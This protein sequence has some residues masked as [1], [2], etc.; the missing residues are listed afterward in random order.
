MSINLCARDF[1]LTAVVMMLFLVTNGCGKGK[2][3]TK[4]SA[5]IEA[6]LA[7]IRQ[8]G[9]PVT[10]AELNQ[11]YVEPPAA[12]NAAALYAQA[13]AALVSEDADSPSFVEKNQ[14]ALQLLHQAAT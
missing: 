8:V 1:K 6:K 4:P 11:W 3:G 7:A 2:S 13:F 5:E 9:E 14:K 10:P 12:E